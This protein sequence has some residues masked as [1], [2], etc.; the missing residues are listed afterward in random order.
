MIV[1]IKTAVSH[2]SS[3]SATHLWYFHAGATS[4]YNE[5]SCAPLGR[6]LLLP[7]WLH[8]STFWRVKQHM[9]RRTHTQSGV[10]Y[11]VKFHSL[12]LW[13]QF[14]PSGVAAFSGLVGD[15]CDGLGTSVLKLFSDIWR[16]PTWENRGIGSVEHRV[17]RHGLSALLL[18][19]SLFGVC[20]LAVNGQ[21]SSSRYSVLVLYV[22]LSRP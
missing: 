22:C 14:Y 2:C 18:C 20:G 16:F 5:S 10:H 6:K 21:M 9:H 1:G 13:V 12:W 15:T 4:R 8:E 19:A 11:V 17:R 7:C 3:Y